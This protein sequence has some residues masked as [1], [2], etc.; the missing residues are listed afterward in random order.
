MKPEDSPAHVDL[1]EDAV[2]RLL[3]VREAAEFLN[4]SEM[5]VRR[6]TNAGLLRCYRIG[7]KRERRFR[8]RELEEY[9]AETTSPRKLRSVL[10]GFG[11][12]E[13]PDGAHL[14]HLS[15]DVREAVDVG[16][17]Y[18]LEGLQG[19]GTV[20]LV[21]PE[22][23][24]RR[25]LRVLKAKGTDV[26]ALRDLGRLHVSAGMANPSEQAA[27]ISRVASASPGRFRLLGDMTWAKQKRWS[28]EYIRSLEDMSNTGT[29]SPG[30]L[31]LC[32]YSLDRFSGQDAMMAVETHKY[33]IYRGAVQQS[34]YFVG[35]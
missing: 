30:K 23:D 11:G 32:Q 29:P 5:T 8:F 16:V 7:R 12:L 6:W 22:A 9:L 35:V 4:V 2:E 24:S 31:I 10:L 27:Y 34:P 1:G 21:A 3:N 19:G 17:S 13:V 18:V 28:T 25:L 26:E 15:L 33:T 14:A 20:L